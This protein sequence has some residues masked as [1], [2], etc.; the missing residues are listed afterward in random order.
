MGRPQPWSLDYGVSLEPILKLDPSLPPQP[1]NQKKEVKRKR[2]RPYLGAQ[3]KM[4]EEIAYLTILSSSVNSFRANG[5][6]NGYKAA[7]DDQNTLWDMAENGVIAAGVINFPICSGKEAS[8]N[9]SKGSNDN[10][11]Y[12]CN[13]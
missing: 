10:P 5:N 12:P 2:I 13:A 11:N 6:K 8:E 3:R 1:H 9:W 4:D 7:L